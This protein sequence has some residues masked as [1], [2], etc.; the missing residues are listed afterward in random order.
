MP[1]TQAKKRN[2]DRDSSVISQCEDS[3][4]SIAA[5][6]NAGVNLSN[7]SSSSGKSRKRKRCSDVRFSDLESEFEDCDLE[8]AAALE[9]KLRKVAR[10]NSLTHDEMMK[11]LHKF[12]KNEHILALVTL[13]AEDELARE[14]QTNEETRAILITENPS[15][16]KLTRA[17]ARELNKTPIL[18]LPSINQE[19]PEIASLIKDDLRSDDEDEEY[20]FQEEDF[21]DDDPNTT[22]SDLESNP[23]TPQTPASQFEDSPVK[24]SD[25]GCFK[26]PLS[27]KAQELSE[28][29][30]IATRTRS[31]LCLQQTTIEDL[32]SEFVPPDLDDPLETADM[33][34]LDED[35][36]QFLN[37]FT[38]PLNATL[39]G[40]DDDPINDP[41]Y[42]AAEKVTVDAEEL[43]DVN[44]SKKELSEL[45]A[46]LYDGLMTEGLSMESI[47]LETPRKFLLS[48][49][50]DRLNTP[51]NSPERLEDNLDVSRQL[52]FENGQQ[53]T[54]HIQ[55][56]QTVT[57]A[58]NSTN[59]L[60]SQ[61]DSERQT[62][63]NVI[64]STSSQQDYTF[65]PDIMST[66]STQNKQ[67]NNEYNNLNSDNM[68]L[69]PIGQSDNNKNIIIASSNINTQL[70][71]IAVPI[72]GQPNCFQ[73]AKVVNGNAENNQSAIQTTENATSSKSLR[74]SK[75]YE[76]NYSREYVSVRRHIIAEYI[77]KFKSLQHAQDN[78]I[79]ST[80]TDT[81][82]AIP[83]NTNTGF[84]QYQYDLM[85]Q[86]LR[87][88]I[89]QL[90]QNYVQTYCHPELW[91]LA[92]KPKELLL[93][94]QEKAKTNVNLQVWNL[95]PAIEL[96]QNW[97]KELDQDTPENTE[98]MN[99]L[100]HE[101][102]V[103]THQIRKIPRF[104]PRIIDCY[105]NSPVFM[106]PQYLP[107]M[108][109][110]SKPSV[111]IF[112]PVESYL[113]AMGLEKHLR[114]IYE[115][116][117]KISFKTTPLRVA[118]KR[119]AKDTVCG[120]RPR[121]IWGHILHLQNVDYYNPI[122]YFFE[123][124][125]A[126]PVDHDPIWTYENNVVLPPKDRIP[127]LPLVFQ[128]YLQKKNEPPKPKPCENK[129]SRKR[130]ST[131]KVS[132]AFRNSYLE[133]VQEA[134]GQDLHMPIYDPVESS[135]T[136]LSDADSNTVIGEKRKKLSNPKPAAKRRLP[137]SLTINVNYVY[138]NGL[139]ISTTSVNSSLPALPAPSYTIEPPQHTPIRDNS[140]SNF[141]N[142]TEAEETNITNL[143]T[144]NSS[145]P[146][147]TINSTVDVTQN[148]L[149]NT[150][151]NPECPIITYNFDWR[152]K[153]LQP[154]FD[155]TINESEPVVFDDSSH[156]P[157]II[158][159][160]NSPHKLKDE[161]SYRLQKKQKIIKKLRRTSKKVGGTIKLH[162]NIKQKSS[163]YR[164]K[165]NLQRRCEE[166]ITT[167]SL[168]LDKLLLKY[169]DYPLIQNY[170]RR[171]KALE[172]YTNLLKKLKS[173]CAKNCSAMSNSTNNSPSNLKRTRSS[174][175][176]TEDDNSPS[177]AR[178]VRKLNRQE[179]NFRHMLLPDTPEE[180]NRKDAIYAFNFY[181]KVEEAFKASNKPEDCKKFNAILKSFDPKKDK[182]SDLYYKLEKLFLPD[183]PELAQ[184]FL[185]FLLPSEA[186]E[187]G[188]FFEHFM[189][190]NM[191]TFINKLNIYFNK[192]PAQIRKIYNSLNDLAEDPDVNMKKVETK[193]IPLLK[194]N[195]FLIDWFM[196]QF[197]QNTPP[198]RLFTN[199]E[200]INL[201][202]QQT[203]R[204]GEYVETV[205]DLMDSP[206]NDAQQQQSCQLR[207]INGRMF[208]GSKMLL[209]AKL[210]FMAAT[211][212]DKPQS[213]DASTSV[214]AC[215]HGIREH[216]EK[217]L[218]AAAD[219]TST[220]TNITEVP[221][222]DDQDKSEEED[223]SKALV[224]DTGDE[225]DSCSSVEL[226]DEATLRSHAT[227]LNPTVYSSTCYATANATSTPNL[228]N[229]FQAH[230][231]NAKKTS[232]NFNEEAKLSPRKNSITT[233]TSSQSNI[234]SPLAAVIC[235]SPINSKD[236]RKSP[237]KKTKSP[238]NNSSNKNIRT[239]HASAVQPMVVI[240]ETNS[241]IQCAKRLKSLIDGDGQ[242]GENNEEVIDSKEI[243][244]IVARTKNSL[245]S[246]QSLTPASTTSICEEVKEET[247]ED[248]EF[249]AEDSALSP[250][251]FPCL[252]ME[253][254][255]NEEDAYNTTPPPPPSQPAAAASDDDCKIDIVTSLTTDVNGSA[256]PSTDKTTTVLPLN[257][258]WTRDEDKI[259]LIE[260]KLGSQNRQELYERIAEKLQN[261]TMFEITSRHQFLM[262]FLS[263]LQGK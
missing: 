136:P 60:D 226:C 187:I 178:Q 82:V 156:L 161:V 166:L 61:Q 11:L 164:E 137:Q 202:D 206:T 174:N 68:A 241:A 224:I 234:T 192:Q 27:K 171:F 218:Q 79:S 39:V 205:T 40:D 198:E 213:N 177:S 55:E 98:L 58:I 7:G 57:N 252:R 54:K 116:K 196:Q 135:D 257:A 88:H 245:K 240:H 65:R 259:I 105:L 176:N 157:V 207:Y 211:Y 46:E 145:L 114:L 250:S 256:V 17:K 20:V 144:S 121:R 175:S 13:K 72:P 95:E 64:T 51:S 16:P 142:S 238:L 66:P 133:F 115:K 50:E 87:I 129:K 97:Q 208:Y 235:N 125:R 186:A 37:D 158:N 152:T 225:E 70:D 42:V 96:I 251:P 172:L 108:P 53:A 242:Q 32:Q 118:C 210:S 155:S 232:L 253:P 221:S 139:D 83:P 248:L 74:D 230:H 43:R 109:F 25:D 34:P 201:K 59:N 153:T 185:T 219:L 261:R 239:N 189:I 47:D 22:A 247:S 163:A 106:Y 2:S 4:S 124:N 168:H 204:T 244:Q 31:K 148:N 154:A 84:T 119:L 29:L 45:V 126:P 188:K 203:N 67:L 237:S 104:H 24:L 159:S 165:R 141:L 162:K 5:G 138:G 77:D 130:S 44:I 200:H 75:P 222:S 223:V 93:D 181:E 117:E 249:L 229:N 28:E 52:E 92:P 183:H 246:T 102:D 195:Q 179:E 63:S 85:Q 243:I 193:I 128:T 134:V 260:M 89:Q 146:D 169:K 120:K 150:A 214:N 212:K 190:N 231:P 41:E 8:D 76:I 197:P 147:S 216:G 9:T 69:I 71:L 21:S 173:I 228:I 220:H 110:S 3:N 99:F 191:T 182:V 262:D 81:T 111:P 6:T 123:H 180:V 140:T 209:P 23:R 78:K 263:K 80:T 184:V 131:V 143:N 151:A 86:Q 30:R 167:Y 49:Q 38:K 90:T 62:A 132:D 236:K 91:K 101:H 15:V 258:A 103:V 112:S 100:H 170:Y 33:Q 1:Q 127:E 217:R 255:S 215:V 94:L 254:D 56:T 194:G 149:N 199:S 10:T 48:Y 35:W 19:D 227:R 113:V 160:S 122:K 36:M 26:V 18:K 14:K 107:R 73:L 12:V 233:A